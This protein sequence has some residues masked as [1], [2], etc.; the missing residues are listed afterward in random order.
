M[1]IQAHPA[2]STNPGCDRETVQPVMSL[3]AN[4]RVRRSPSALWR[5]GAF[6]VVVLGPRGGLP[7]TLAGTGEPLWAL[8]DEYRSLGD[9]AHLLSEAYGHDPCGVLVDLVPVIELM[10]ARDVCERET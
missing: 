3:D 4:V 1:S 7:L 2:A 5:R 8:L 6:G 9:L 10:L